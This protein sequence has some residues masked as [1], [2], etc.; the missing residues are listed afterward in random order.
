[1]GNCKFANE[2]NRLCKSSSDSIDNTE[3]F[4]DFKKYMHVTRTA[5]E[6]LK[7]I[8]RNVNAGNKKTLVLLCGSA[9]DGKSHLL[10]YL[11]NSDEEHLIENYTIF[12]DATESKRLFL[13]LSGNCCNALHS[14]L[15]D[16]RASIP[17]TSKIVTSSS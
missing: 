14:S 5:E 15:P 16:T 3:K 9:G 17:Y 4:D 12:N 1:M 7:A 13:F 6:D 2:L 8:L 11:K 10:S